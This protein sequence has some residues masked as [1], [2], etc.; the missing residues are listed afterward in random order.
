MASGICLI[1]ASREYHQPCQLNAIAVP[2]GV[3]E[4][5][6]RKK[7]LSDYNT[8]IGAGLGPLKGKIWRIGLMGVNANKENVK[9]CLSTLGQILKG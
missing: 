5:V 9:A 6:V 2:E 1:I 3:D 4:L 7:F 8:E